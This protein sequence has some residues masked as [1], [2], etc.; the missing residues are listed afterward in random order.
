MTKERFKILTGGREEEVGDGGQE[1]R[2]AEWYGVRQG[3]GKEARRQGGKEAKR[4]G[5]RGK[6]AGEGARGPGGRECEEEAAGDWEA[7]SQ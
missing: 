5:G 3:G 4:Q 6:G 7:W 2:E 1:G